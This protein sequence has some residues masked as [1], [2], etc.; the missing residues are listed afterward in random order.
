MPKNTLNVAIRRLI[1]NVNIRVLGKRKFE[2]ND[3]ISIN[4]GVKLF[5]DIFSRFR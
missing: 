2:N 1:K 4:N 3:K 5:C